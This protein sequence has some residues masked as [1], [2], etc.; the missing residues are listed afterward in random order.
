MALKCPHDPKNYYHLRFCKQIRKAATR[1]WCK[2]C[3]HFE[4]KK[5]NDERIK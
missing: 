4:E 2:E 1:S 5:A 3:H